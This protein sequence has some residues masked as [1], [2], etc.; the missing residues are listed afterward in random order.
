MDLEDEKKKCNEDMHDSSYRHPGLD[1]A[2]L[3]GR[4]G[5][6]VFLIAMDAGSGSGMTIIKNHIRKVTRVFIT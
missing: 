6:I 5:S 4:Q 1:P 3:S 2:C